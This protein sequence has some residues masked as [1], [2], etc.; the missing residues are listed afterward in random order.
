MSR[1]TF[2][3]DASVA[4]KWVLREENQ[5]TALQIQEL[6]QDEEV[7]LV[8]PHLLIAEVGNILWKRV[9]RG[10][11]TAAAAARCFQQLQKDSPIL[12]DSPAVNTSALHLAIAH[13]QT[14]YD[15]LYLAW[16]LEQRCDLIT[17]D[18]KFFLAVRPAFACVRLLSHW[19]GIP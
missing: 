4:V 1:P 19:D 9:R 13:G 12:L 16:A 11:L 5:S 15:C 18:E 7:D 10:E 6:Y 8:A 17:A 3:V 14:L 2:V